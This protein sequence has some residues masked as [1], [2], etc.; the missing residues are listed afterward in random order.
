MFWGRKS[1]CRN[2][3]AAKMAREP[4]ATSFDRLN[5]WFLLFPTF[6]PCGLKSSRNWQ[7]WKVRDSQAPH[8]WPESA[9]KRRSGSA[10]HRHQ[11]PDVAWPQ[12][13]WEGRRDRSATGENGPCWSRESRPPWGIHVLRLVQA[14]EGRSRWAWMLC[15]GSSLEL[16]PYTPRAGRPQ[17][18]QALQVLFAGH[19]HPG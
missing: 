6:G 4:M 1:F 10:T 13:T 8:T 17:E 19:L 12:E 18:D 2:A 5:S 14:P 15:R 11:P 9:L 3:Q 7:T 16:A